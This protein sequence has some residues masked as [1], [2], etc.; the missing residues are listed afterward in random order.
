V[1]N[2]KV[3]T[4][5]LFAFLGESGDECSESKAIPVPFSRTL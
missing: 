1:K 5:G 4:N 2:K 3:Y